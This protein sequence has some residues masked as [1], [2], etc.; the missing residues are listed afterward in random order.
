MSSCN[1][2]RA[3][4]FANSPDGWRHLLDWLKPKAFTIG[5]V[6]ILDRA[7]TEAFT[8]VATPI[9]QNAGGRNLYTGLGK[10]VARVGEAPKGVI[11][12]EWDSLEKAEAYYKSTYTSLSP[13]RDKAYKTIRSFLVE[14]NNPNFTGFTQGSKPK[15]YWIR[16]LEVIDQAALDGL[17]NAVSP[18]LRQKL[19]AAA[20]EAGNQATGTN[21][22]KIIART[23]E[24]PKRFALQGFSSLEQA[25]AYLKSPAYTSSL[26]LIDKAYKTTRAYL[27][28]ATQ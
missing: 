18:D 2:V 21:G 16:E 10:I 28:E 8:K 11:L 24:P 6:E 13:Q 17:A 23:G 26:P 12:V 7:A 27:V 19:Q 20:Q 22:G 9:V 1:K 4:S 5:E 25:E 15:A 14:A 3:R